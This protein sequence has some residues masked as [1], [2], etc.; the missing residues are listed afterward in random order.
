MCGE[1]L[2]TK[3]RD[4]R[5]VHVLSTVHNDELIDTDNGQQHSSR[6]GR[7]E[8]KKTK[9]VQIIIN[10]N[11]V[12]INLIKLCLISLL[13]VKEKIVFFM[14]QNGFIHKFYKISNDFQMTLREYT[15]KVGRER[16]EKSSHSFE[17]ENPL[18][19]EKPV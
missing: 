10:T 4:V 16:V 7:H 18:T 13:D 17:E 1:I 19:T 2:V 3:R 15:I 8:T 5:D 6:G 12:Y 11:W 9:T 14:F